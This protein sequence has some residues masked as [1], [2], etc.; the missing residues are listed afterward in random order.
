MGRLISQGVA[1]LGPVQCTGVATRPDCPSR[2]QCG[3]CVQLRRRW[4]L[5]RLARQSASPRPSLSGDHQPWCHWDRTW[6]CNRPL[7]S[8]SNFALAILADV[9][10]EVGHACRR[11]PRQQPGIWAS[12]SPS[13]R[14]SW[15]APELPDS[16]FGAAGAAPRI[17]PDKACAHDTDAHAFPH[18][19]IPA[20]TDMPKSLAVF[21]LACA[22]YT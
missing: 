16:R 11:L 20:P 13:L 12:P 2:S 21:P 1:Y 18:H 7:L 19:W 5:Q 9:S 10:A 17:D 3:R 14:F 6:E 22:L 4:Q 8:R 15:R